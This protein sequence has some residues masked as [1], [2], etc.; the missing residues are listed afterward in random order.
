MALVEIFEYRLN[1]NPRAEVRAI[2]QRFKAAMEAIQGI[3]R[4]N[5]LLCDDD[6]HLLWQIIHWDD[7]TPPADA[8]KI[9]WSLPEMS[10]FTTL[11]AS[12]P[13]R[14]KNLRPVSETE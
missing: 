11:M 5:F 2:S 14:V 8:M 4:V 13:R 6:P 9:Y 7:E 3:S 1:D 10:L 12:P